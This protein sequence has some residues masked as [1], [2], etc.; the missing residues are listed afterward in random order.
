MEILSE[1][2]LQEMARSWQESLKLL[3]WEVRVEQVR[4]DVL[5]KDSG[6]GSCSFSPHKRVAIIR[7]L[8][9]DDYA[10]VNQVIPSGMAADFEQ[11]RTLVHELLHLPFA[12]L[13]AEIGT[14]TA[15]EVMLEQAINSFDALLVELARV[16]RA[17]SAAE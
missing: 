16:G 1:E 13:D 9:P 3:D 5:G 12:A 7:L 14:G 17:M 10:E 15:A 11:E 2:K 4:I 6:F 8:H